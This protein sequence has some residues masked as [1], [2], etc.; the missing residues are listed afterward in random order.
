M[1]IIP[2]VERRIR[3][4]GTSPIPC[5]CTISIG[6]ILSFCPNS[7]IAPYA[8]LNVCKC[9]HI[10]DCDENIYTLHGGPL[11]VWHRVDRE[12]GALQLFSPDPIAVA[13]SL[14]AQ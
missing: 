3:G 12:R 8:F 4:A 5:T 14:T 7:R 13:C 11:H 1:V 6:Y 10:V 2:Q 9:S